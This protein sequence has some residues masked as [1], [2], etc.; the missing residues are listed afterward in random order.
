[1]TPTKTNNII[2]DKDGK[3]DKTTK[4]TGYNWDFNDKE[5]SLDEIEKLSDTL[6]LDKKLIMNNIKKDKSCHL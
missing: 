1:M 6:N 2:T 3:Q 5:I 4:N